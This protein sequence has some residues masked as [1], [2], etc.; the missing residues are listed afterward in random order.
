MID[1]SNEKL[2]LNYP[3]NWIYKVIGSNETE[4]QIAVKEIV[5]QREYT[6]KHSHISKKGKFLSFTLEL[7]V[8]NEDDRKML[9]EMLCAHKDIKMVL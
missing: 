9:Y 4:I 1:L 5:E 6:L 8:H 3:C 7:L 2:D